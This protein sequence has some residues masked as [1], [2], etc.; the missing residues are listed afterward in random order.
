MTKRLGPIVLSCLISACGGEAPPAAGSGPAWGDS[1]VLRE[2]LRIGGL[3]GAEEYTFGYVGTVAPSPDGSLYVTDTQVP[4]IRTYDQEGTHVG[5]VG[6]PGQGPGE[7]R[8]VG[9]M[10][11]DAEGRLT[12]WDGG[13][14]RLST[15]GPDGEYL[16]SIPVRNGVAGW[17]ILAAGP[18]GEVYL[19]VRGEGTPQNVEGGQMDWARICPE[20]T[21]ERLHPVPRPDPVGPRYVLAGRGGYY[22]PFVTMTVDAIGPDGSHYWARNDEY[23]IHRV[24]P[25]GE[26]SVLTRG[27][28]PIEVSAEEREEWTARSESFAE[29]SPENRSDYFPIPEVKPFL[30][31]L[32]VDLDGRLWVSRYT[33]AAHMPYSPEYQQERESQGLPSYNWRDTLTWDVFSDAGELL[34][35]VTF[36]FRTSFVTA[37]GDQV[38]GIQAGEY[39]EDYVVR[40]RIES[41]GS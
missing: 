39:R 6:R 35:V 33:E 36:P 4:L 40:W 5:D 10:V 11:V 32:A 19:Q 13:N 2:E 27:V 7:Y 18:E 17:R 29:R 23:V 12:I 9:P 41:V 22:R 38:W 8:S 28:D 31:E 3:D 26:E 16:T 25:D 21:M 20:G 14:G 30:R 15:F 24:R 37:T 1:I 34:G